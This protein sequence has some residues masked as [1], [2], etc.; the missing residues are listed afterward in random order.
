MFGIV[1]VLLQN[2]VDIGMCVDVKIVE[3][4]WELFYGVQFYFIYQ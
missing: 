1:G 2:I 4:L 3:L